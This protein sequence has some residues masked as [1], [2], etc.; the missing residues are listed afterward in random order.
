MGTIGRSSFVFFSGFLSPDGP[1]FCKQV[2]P[3]M[4]DIFVM[5]RVQLSC[6]PLCRN[7]IKFGHFDTL[8]YRS[9]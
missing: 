9:A 4:K 8:R 6:W 3:K 2:V 5:P 7:E 1:A